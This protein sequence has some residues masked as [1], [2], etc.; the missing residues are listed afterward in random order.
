MDALFSGLV[1]MTWREG[2]MLVIGGALIYLAIVKE[3]EPVL[4]LPIGFGAILAN[5]PGSS[6]VGPHGFLT[7]LYEAGIITELFPIL[8]S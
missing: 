8:I 3:Y 2:L 5:I 7:I 1:N 6:A 4:L